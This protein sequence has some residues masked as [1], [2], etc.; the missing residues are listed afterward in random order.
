M[1][2]FK[3]ILIQ[4]IKFVFK[5]EFCGANRVRNVEEERASVSVISFLV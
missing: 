4:D 3:N 1:C 5:R 2:A